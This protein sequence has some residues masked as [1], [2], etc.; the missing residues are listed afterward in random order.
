MDVKAYVSQ[1]LQV[2]KNVQKF[3]GSNYYWVLRKVFYISSHKK[4][5]FFGEGYFIKDNVA[6]FLPGL[7]PNRSIALITEATFSGLKKNH[8]SS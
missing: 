2:L 3:C 1:G 7:M 4:R 6:S 8:I 5:T